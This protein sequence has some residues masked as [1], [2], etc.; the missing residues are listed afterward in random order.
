MKH[1]LISFLL[2]FSMVTSAAASYKDA[3]KL[4][5]AGKYQES[6]NIIAAKLVVADDMTPDS[7]NYKMRFLAA[8]NHWKLSSYNSAVLHFQRCMQIRKDL[9]DP[10]VDLALML[11]DIK[12]FNDS[13]HY[14]KRGLEVKQD[15]MLYFVY[16][17]L[18]YHFK[19]YLKAKEFFEKSI[20]LDPELYVSYNSLG[21]TFIAM[22]NY[23]NAY[24]AFSAA[25]AMSPR[26]PEIFNNVGFSLEK[27]QK[28][29]DAL[30]Y[31]EKA[32]LLQPENTVIK[33]NLE[34]VKLL[35]S[36]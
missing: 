36:K 28:I 18:A 13:E 25:S 31:Y 22:N 35:V 10:Y 3:L 4:F 12:K 34:R 15:P 7:P 2:I 30:K 6:L 23:S 5:E 21:L 11:Y 29:P 26:S 14:V 8:H 17:K 32:M 33:A 16:G 1:F 20:S 19:N 24:T 27:L 9:T